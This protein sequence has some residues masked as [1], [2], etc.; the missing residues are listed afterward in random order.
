MDTSKQFEM[1]YCNFVFYRSNNFCVKVFFSLGCVARTG[2]GFAR[3]LINF[4][5]GAGAANYVFYFNFNF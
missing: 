5:P 3:G 1:T 2:T 4:V